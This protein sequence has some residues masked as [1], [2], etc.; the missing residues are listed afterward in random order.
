VVLAILQAR[1]SSSRFPGKVLHPLHGKPMILRQLERLQRA[2]RIDDIVVATSVES[3]DDELAAV[4]AANGHTVRRGPLDDVLGRFV[5]VIA[6]FAPDHVVRLTAD[7]PLMDPAVVD[8]IVR[9]HLESGVDYTSNALSHTFPHGLDVEAARADVLC[10]VAELSHDPDDREHV[11]MG[12]YRRPEQ[13]SLRPVAQEPDRSDLRWTV[14]YPDD[15][16]WVEQVYA[17]LYPGNPAFGQPDVVALIE[18][19][20]ELRRTMSAHPR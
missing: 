7:N 17:A 4:L 14:D 15:L 11:T 19:H 2:T 5:Q 16:A 1:M 9:E 18:E 12:I 13:F 3:S 20:P 8:L 10:Q 6:E